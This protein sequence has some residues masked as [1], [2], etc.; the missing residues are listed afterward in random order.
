MYTHTYTQIHIPA[1]LTARPSSPRVFSL[2]LSLSCA[3]A[4]ANGE[5]RMANGERTDEN[6]ATSCF[7]K[8]G[9]KKK[10]KSKTKQKKKPRLSVWQE[11]TY[12]HPTWQGR[13]DTTPSTYTL[14]PPSLPP[15]HSLTPSLPLPLLR[16][17]RSRRAAS[18]SRRCPEHLVTQPYSELLSIE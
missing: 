11:I 13:Q 5:R 7:R 10:K 14:R 18:K 8:G 4:T 16:S 15:S 2:S 12:L 17:F 6:A 9:G 1:F 3:P